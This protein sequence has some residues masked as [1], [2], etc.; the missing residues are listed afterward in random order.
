MVNESPSFRVDQ[1]PYGGIK[2]SGNTK[3]GPAYAV[4]EMTDQRLI[5]MRSLSAKD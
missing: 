4:A 5:A 2:S 1:M 3:E